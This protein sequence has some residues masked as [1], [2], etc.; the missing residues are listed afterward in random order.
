MWN[1]SSTLFV[2][3]IHGKDSDCVSFAMT[4]QSI[5]LL[6]TYAGNIASSLNVTMSL[7]SRISTKWKIQPLVHTNKSESMHLVT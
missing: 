7:T 3:S 6:I 2:N 5:H 4:P 1:I